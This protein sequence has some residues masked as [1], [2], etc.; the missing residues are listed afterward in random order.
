MRHRSIFAGSLGI[1]R[2]SYG[3]EPV[4]MG[5]GERDLYDKPKVGRVDVIAHELCA[6]AA[7]VMKQE[8]QGIP[9]AL[10]RGVNYKK[11]ECRYSERMENIEEYAK[12]LKYIIKHTFRVLG[13]NIY[14][15]HN[16][17]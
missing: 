1:A 12:A 8:S 2:G 10:I 4:E 16:Y 13:L 15:K 7:L 9:V 5:F 6:A 3:I 17:R 11:C 14:L